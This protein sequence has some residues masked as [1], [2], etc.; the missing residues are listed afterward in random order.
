MDMIRQAL[1]ECVDDVGGLRA[2]VLAGEGTDQAMTAGQ[3]GSELE[4]L[5]ARLTACVGGLSR[6][7]E[8]E[9]ARNDGAAQARSEGFT[10]QAIAQGGAQASSPVPRAV[11]ERAPDPEP[12][13]A[14]ADTVHAG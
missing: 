10:G 3:I 9:A 14:P 5:E 2:R 11:E 6:A 13:A 4:N 8:L 7:I 1:V 12:A